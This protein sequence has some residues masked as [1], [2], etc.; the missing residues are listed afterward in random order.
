MGGGVAV[1]WH[2]D[3]LQFRVLSAGVLET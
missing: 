1:S 2:L 3:A